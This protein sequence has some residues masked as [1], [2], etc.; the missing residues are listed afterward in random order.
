MGI[1]AAGTRGL[2]FRS[3]RNALRRV[4]AANSR[5]R[6][7]RGNG[8]FGS[9]ARRFAA[10]DLGTSRALP[11]K[12]SRRRGNF[13]FGSIPCSDTSRRGRVPL[14]D[15]RWGRSLERSVSG[16]STATPRCVGS[17]RSKFLMRSTVARRRGERP[18]NAS[19]TCRGGAHPA[20]SDLALPLIRRIPGARLWPS[21]ST[22]RSSSR[23]WNGASTECPDSFV[24]I[25]RE[26]RNRRR[27]RSH[28]RVRYLSC[29]GSRLGLRRR[30]QRALRR[31]G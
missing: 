20:G 1:G 18:L 28:C 30:R 6:L 22:R 14:R 24:Q 26:P 12:G 25:T 2:P 21:R 5:L 11:T 13:P 19:G 16:S 8:P 9:E 23:T 4:A 29:P 31:W 7:E 3:T 10:S 27:G 15:S 17:P